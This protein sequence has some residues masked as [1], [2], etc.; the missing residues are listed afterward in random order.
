MIINL[1]NRE[2]AVEDLSSLLDTV[3]SRRQTTENEWLDAHS[4]WRGKYTKSFYKSETFN[5]YVPLFRRAIERYAVRG[6]QMVL[7]SDTFF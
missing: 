7:P 3:R 1:D 2:K 5:H 4:A 6:A